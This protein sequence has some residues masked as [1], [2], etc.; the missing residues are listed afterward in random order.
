MALAEAQLGHCAEA[1][2]HLDQYLAATKN[3]VAGRVRGAAPLSAEVRAPA[4]A[5]ARAGSAAP[6]PTHSA[7]ASRGRLFLVDLE[8]GVNVPLTS[9]SPQAAFLGRIEL[10]VALSNRIGLDLVLLAES[11]VSRAAVNPDGSLR[12]IFSENLLLGV[13]ERRVVWRRL[14]VFGTVAAGIL[15]DSYKGFR[16]AVALHFD[17][18]AAWELGPGEVRVRPLDFGVLVETDGADARRAVSPA[19]RMGSTAAPRRRCRTAS[20]SVPTGRLA[21]DLGQPGGCPASTTFCRPGCD[22]NPGSTPSR[23]DRHASCARRSAEA[24]VRLVVDA[25]VRVDLRDG[26][27]PRARQQRPHPGTRRRA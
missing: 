17:A 13:E 15:V 26:Q 21:A 3:P 19:T 11:L 16:N 27:R 8:A 2:A 23:I 24:A 14:A 10:G 7:H 1:Q 20:A 22:A 4:A 12:T 5:P 9:G 25:V 18:G 6:T